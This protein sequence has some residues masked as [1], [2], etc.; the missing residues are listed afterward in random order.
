MSNLAL[1]KYVYDDDD[2]EHYIIFNMQAVLV[3]RLCT[4]W[5]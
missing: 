2:D 1:V 3:Y 5:H 4:S